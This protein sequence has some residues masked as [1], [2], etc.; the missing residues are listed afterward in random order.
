MVS[1]QYP[2][3]PHLY[4][5]QKCTANLKFDSD[6]ITFFFSDG[7]SSVFQPGHRN[8]TLKDGVDLAEEAD[9][10]IAR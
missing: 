7:R 4:N 2:C 10:I 3:P 6:I 9:N 1:P 8:E 5:F